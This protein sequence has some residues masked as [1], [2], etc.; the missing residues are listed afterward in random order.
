MARLQTLTPTQLMF[1]SFAPSLLVVSPVA[2][3]SS[4]LHAQRS[5]QRQAPLL[6]GL[7]YVA[8]LSLARV[9]RQALFSQN[10]R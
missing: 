10:A 7:N 9:S 8:K 2:C 5:G 4:T 6:T 1:V 3:A